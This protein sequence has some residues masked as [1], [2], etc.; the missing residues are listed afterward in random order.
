MVQWFNEE[1]L[2]SDSAPVVAVDGNA[3]NPHYL[4][5]VE[6]WR[7][8]SADQVLLLDLWGKTKEP[9]AVFADITLGRRDRFTR[10]VGNGTCIQRNRGR[11]GCGG[12]A[13]EDAARSAA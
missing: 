6:Q 7:P 10:T 3:G 2:L 13:V 11:A 5:T 12:E 8:I 1:G 9:G 4:P